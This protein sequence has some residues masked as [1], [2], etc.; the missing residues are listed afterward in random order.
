M[1]N[2]KPIVVPSIWANQQFISRRSL[3]ARWDKSGA[4]IK[5][6]EKSGVLR[7]YRIGRDARYSLRDIAELEAKW[8]GAE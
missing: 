5:R 7:S 2:P 1:E 8:R 6:M 3:A 4:S